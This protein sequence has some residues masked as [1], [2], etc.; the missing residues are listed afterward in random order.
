MTEKL[1]GIPSSPTGG[2]ASLIKEKHCGISFPDDL[3]VARPNMHTQYRVTAVHALGANK[4][5]G[6]RP[7]QAVSFL[8]FGCFF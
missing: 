3:C 1:R 7:S 4:W 2:S 6:L 8:C 5:Y